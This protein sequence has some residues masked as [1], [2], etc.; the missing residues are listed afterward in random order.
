MRTEWS[1]LSPIRCLIRDETGQDLVEYTFVV[2]LIA[3]AA[4]AVMQP[5]AVDINNIMAGIGL[6]LTASG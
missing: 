6:M 3:S 1:M 5:L 2:A 4:V